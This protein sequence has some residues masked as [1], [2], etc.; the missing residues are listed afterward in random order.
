MNGIIIVDKPAGFTSH[1]V[2]A[3]LRRICGTRRVGHSGTLDPM[4]TGV[5]PIF[6][7]RATRACEFAEGD[8]K[9]YTARLL[10]GVVTD[11]QDITGTVLSECTPDVTEQQVLSACAAFVGDIQQTPPMY[12][13]VKVNGKRLYSLARQGV[14]VERKARRICIR[15]IGV[16]RV[17]PC[18]YDLDVHCSKGT[19]IRTL[20]HDIG[21]FLGCGGT[22]EAL[23]RTAAG[24]FTLSDAHTLEELEAGGAEKALLPVDS[25][26]RHYPAHVLDG[27]QVKA[28]KNGAT[29]PAPVE[30]GVTYRVYAPD[31]EFLMLGV[32]IGEKRRSLKTV[33]SFFEVDTDGK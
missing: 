7:G 27:A 21:A 31:G 30:C 2:V 32:G 6:V 12:S 22:M 15:S 10:L 25:L 9:V 5:L 16:K 20:C 33:K 19:Y 28:C 8:S 17:S 13:A 24:G 29:V 1:D 3:K 14:E 26:F 11:T 18:R 23:R 4:A